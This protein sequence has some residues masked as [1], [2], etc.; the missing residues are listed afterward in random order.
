MIMKQHKLQYGKDR[1]AI[2]YSRIKLIQ[3]LNYDS[4]EREKFELLRIIPNHKK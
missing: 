1:P 3:E 2:G 4:L